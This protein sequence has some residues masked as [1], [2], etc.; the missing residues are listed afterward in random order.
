MI[1]FPI[2]W[3]PRLAHY[4]LHTRGALLFSEIDEYFLE[5]LEYE[6]LNDVISRNGKLGDFVMLEKHAALQIKKINRI[7]E[8]LR[9]NVLVRDASLAN[10]YLTPE[11]SS[12]LS[13]ENVNRTET[14][15][16]SCA[17]NMYEPSFAE[18]YSALAAI[19]GPA[20]RVIVDDYLDP[21]LPQLQTMFNEKQQSWQLV[22]LSGS[23]HRIGPTF[24]TVD[25]SQ[26]CY[27][28]LRS[29]LVQN[30]P[31][32][33][34]FRRYTRKLHHEPIPVQ[35][36]YQE[37]VA[38]LEHF[39]HSIEQCHWNNQEPP[40]YQRY[41]H[42]PTGK[43]HSVSK[44]PQCEVCG[45]RQAFVKI[46]RPPLVLNS[47]KKIA[48]NDGG[49][50]CEQR[51]KTLNKIQSLIDPITG[52]I[53]HLQDISNAS[54][55][56]EMSIYRAAYFQNSHE[57]GSISPETFVQLS[58]GKGVS[59]EQ[60]HASALGEA[61]ERQA[62]QYVGDENAILSPPNQLQHRACVPHNLCP[63]S[64]QQYK[65]FETF[66]GVSLSQ[67]QWVK[68]YSSASI[69]WLL[70]WSYTHNEGVHFPASYCLAN[71]PFEDRVY[72]L[73]NHNGNAAGNTNEEAILQGTLEVIERDAVALWWYNQIPRPEIDLKIVPK[74][75]RRIIDATLK[76]DWNYWLLDISNDIAVVSCVAVG[77][78]K[79]NGKF[80]LGFGAHL[81]PAIACTR[82]LTEM[83]QLIVIKDKVTGP[84]NFGAI[85]SHPFLYPKRK[86]SPRN[87]LDFA[88]ISTDNIKD[89]ILYLIEILK[90][91]ALELCV[92]SYSRPDINLKTVKVIVPGLCHFWPQFGNARL[93]DVPVKMGWLSKPLKELELNTM[94]LYL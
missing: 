44:R 82:A 15:T 57:Y 85:E 19:P 18:I 16:L 3:H 68:R 31:V 51:S 84:F 33:E 77:Q 6:S 55:P 65:H 52:I 35:Y 5:R 91:C 90:K 72:S 66:T 70:G 14:Y 89:D 47:D 60:A 8:L 39:R 13:R 27:Q 28:C 24:N 94:D 2:Q 86:T 64:E 48:D 67:P 53:S 62:A 11:F 20:V 45:D 71:T 80:V 78:H 1:N 29:R 32:R 30:T 92:V 46:N 87:A 21:R 26:A 75:Q 43:F 61:L 7:D 69:H 36:D 50:R 79:K 25:K 37:S 40:L 59:K 23:Q 81:D 56:D 63:F 58:L 88:I 74:A 54:N 4:T 22:K 42:S 34:W 93:Y 76:K 17:L 38:T 41:I 49:Y 73:Y 83:Y 12:P 10:R 9:E